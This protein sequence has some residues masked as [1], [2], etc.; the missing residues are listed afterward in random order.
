[1]KDRGVRKGMIEA[2]VTESDRKEVEE[3][4]EG[5]WNHKQEELSKTG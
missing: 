2:T 5:T 1:M 4:G 3:E